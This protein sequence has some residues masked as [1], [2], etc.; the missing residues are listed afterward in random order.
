MDRLYYLWIIF[1][2]TS[3]EIIKYWFKKGGIGLD[4]AENHISKTQQYLLFPQ[5]NC[6][7]IWRG[8]WAFLLNWARSFTMK[9]DLF[10]SSYSS[11]LPL[12]RFP[13]MSLLE[14]S[15]ILI[16]TTLG[17]IN[18]PGIVPTNTSITV[19]LQFAADTAGASAKFRSLPGGRMICPS[20]G[21]RSII[22][23]QTH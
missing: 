19:W 8:F 21:D 13:L 11:S 18:S 5:G 1:Q 14:A 7:L 10:F 16:I 23:K 12:P 22:N 6:S 20:I 2:D 17:H 4:T 15:V 9:E 3:V